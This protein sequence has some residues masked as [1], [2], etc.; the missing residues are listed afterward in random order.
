[1]KTVDPQVPSAQPVSYANYCTIAN[2]QL[3][4]SEPGLSCCCC[5]CRTFVDTVAPRFRLGCFVLGHTFSQRASP[6]PLDKNMSLESHIS[7]TTHK[8]RADTHLERV[9]PRKALVAVIARERFDGKMDPLVSLQIMISIEALRTLITFE[10]PIMRWCLLRRIRPLLA[11]HT[12]RIG[13]VATVEP[14][15]QHTSLHVAHHGHLCPRTVN[16]GH[17]RTRHGWQRI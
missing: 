9:F 10:R 16:V 4:A 5:R 6:A 15:G 12:L 17:D 3:D 1:M 2:P 8:W 14:H 13:G 7:I 11:V